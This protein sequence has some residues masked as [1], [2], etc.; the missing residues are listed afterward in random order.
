[1]YHEK[2]SLICLNTTICIN[3]SIYF[4]EEIE[5]NSIKELHLYKFDFSLIFR[6]YY[7]TI[8]LMCTHLYCNKVNM[9]HDLSDKFGLSVVFVL[10][11]FCLFVSFYL[12]CCLLF[13][14]FFR[15]WIL[16]LIDVCGFFSLLFFL[17]N[18]HKQ[19]IIPSSNH[20]SL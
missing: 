2:G 3:T 7:F 5:I 15:H 20:N 6:Y 17:S 13:L 18:Y 19:Y 4:E 1:M 11:Y 10:L 12:V 14:L 16:H 8:P 9:E